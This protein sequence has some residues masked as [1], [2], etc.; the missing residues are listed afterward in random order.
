VDAAGAARLAQLA[1]HFDN[2]QAGTVR[3]ALRRL[4]EAEGL[5]PRERLTTPAPEPAR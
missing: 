1:Q 2:S 4:A 5:E 3:L